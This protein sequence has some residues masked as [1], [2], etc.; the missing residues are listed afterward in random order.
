[1]VR[2][3]RMMPPMPSVSAMVW[4]SPNR[5]GTSK[6]VTVHGSFE[7]KSCVVAYRVEGMVHAAASVHRDRESLELEFFLA[8]NDQAAIER[9]LAGLG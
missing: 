8:H 6:S 4:R 2:S 5:F 3:P 7:K 1:M 9:L